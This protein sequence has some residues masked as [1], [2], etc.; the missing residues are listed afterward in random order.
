VLSSEPS[1]LQLRY[2]QTLAEIAGSGRNSTTIFPIPIDLIRPFYEQ[3]MERHP[4]PARPT[5][6]GTALGARSGGEA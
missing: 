5:D 1:G 2:L 3:L 6:A 4:A